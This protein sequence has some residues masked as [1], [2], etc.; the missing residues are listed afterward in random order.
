MDFSFILTYFYSKRIAQS[1]EVLE[2]RVKE[3]VEKNKEQEQ[4]K[5]LS[6]RLKE[7]M[8]T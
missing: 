1:H 8:L 4:L 2:N 6:K 5:G 7:V 3:E